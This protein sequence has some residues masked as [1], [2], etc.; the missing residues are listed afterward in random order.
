LTFVLEAT[1]EQF[2]ELS[3]CVDAIKSSWSDPNSGRLSFMKHFFYEVRE[4]NI[5]LYMYM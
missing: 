4:E 2:P 1:R 5:I 3:A